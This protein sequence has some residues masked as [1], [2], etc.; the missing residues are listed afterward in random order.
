MYINP[1]TTPVETGYGVTANRF[2]RIDMAPNETTFFE[3]S[4]PIVM[5]YHDSLTVEVNH[6]IQ[7]EQ[8]LVLQ[9]IS[10]SMATRMFDYGY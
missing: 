7:V 8:V 5:T 9:L 1:N 2:M 6:Q 10:L 3:S 4:Y